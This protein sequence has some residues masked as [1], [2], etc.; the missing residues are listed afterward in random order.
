[1]QRC[2][3][4]AYRHYIARIGMPP[5]PML[6]DYA[7]VIDQHRAFVATRDGAIVGLL[8]LIETGSGMLLDN[9][10]VH[11][12]QQGTGLGH[13]LLDLAESVAR[14]RGYRQLDLYTH[15]LMHE[16]IALYERI[17][18]RET[19]R[20]TE[21]G[22][23]RVYLRKTLISQDEPRP[24]NMKLYGDHRSGNCYKIEL[25]MA[26]LELPYDWVDVDILAGETRTPAFLARNPN[27]KIPVLELPDGRCLSES[28]AILNFLAAGSAYLPED[29]FDLAK[30][31]QWQFFEQYSHEPYI[32][33]ARFIARYLDL[34]DG[35]RAEYEAKQAG[36]H[37]AL[38]V[39][40]TQL[41]RTPFL[42]GERLTSADI[43]LYGYTHVAH[44][45]GF[46]LA[47]YPAIQGWLKRIEDQPNY[48]GMA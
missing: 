35:R 30:V 1:M 27:G 42:V 45:G 2:A 28:N 10:A 4:A 23:D 7:A 25:L 34:P 37:R 19:A 14:S 43:A 16:N 11:P 24:V 9:V 6:D 5:G 32:A 38:A 15:T 48:V 26:L 20:R 44:E 41:S 12:E 13:R 40:E 31:Q 3:Q 46:D 18:Y 22:Y 47:A 17:G 21:H 33:V 29:W 36:G 8:V 39:M